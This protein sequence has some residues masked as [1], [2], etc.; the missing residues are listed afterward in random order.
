M[1]ASTDSREDLIWLEVGPTNKNPEVIAKYYLDAVL[2]TGGVP[3]K[4]RSDDGT[5]N[6]SVEALQIFLR[7]Q[8]NDEYSGL[9]SFAIG[10]STS[11]QRI[12]AYW[13]HLI[14]DGPGWWANFFKDLRDFDLFDYSDIYGHTQ[15]RVEKIAEMWNQ[16]IIASSKSSNENGPRGRPDVCI[17]YHTFLMQKTASNR[18]TEM[19]QMNFMTILQC[20]S[21]TFRMSLGSLL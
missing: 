14:R 13:S 4:I 7:S 3:Q 6:S 16:H 2:Q 5:E 15:G 21:K 1:V 17:F 10:T 19:K 11:N 12:E 20:L 8:H 18:L 9:A